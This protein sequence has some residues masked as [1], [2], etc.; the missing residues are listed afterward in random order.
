M[1]RLVR[2]GSAPLLVALFVLP[3]LPL[4][5][6]GRLG[7]E[8]PPDS[9]SPVDSSVDSGGETV[10]E[11]SAEVS[12]E[13][14]PDVPLDVP[15]DS[16][17]PTPKTCDTLV[18]AICGPDTATCCSKHSFTFGKSGCETAINYYCGSM[19][20]AVKAGTATYDESYLAGCAKAWGTQMKM[21]DMD[22]ITYTKLGFDCS[23]LFN[24]TKA[25]G[26]T[27][28]PSGYA[29]CKAPVGSSAYCDRSAKKCRV[30]T[31]VG[32]GA[33]CNFYGS[34]IHYCD[35]G[36]Y[37]DLTSSTS[38]CQTAKKL[39]DACDGP[40]DFSCGLYN[41]CKD[42]KCTPGL[43]DGADCTVNSECASYQCDKGKCT[44]PNVTLAGPYICGSGP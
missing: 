15:K 6:G 34:S 14:A 43:G 37:C 21:C 1:N 23:Q 28:N 11:T 44:D 24:G 17:P 19:V 42:N 26:D 10:S 3:A 41:V 29:E 36:L 35:L 38:V 31:V 30:Y 9:G 7:I 32:K 20:D 27:C 5:C 25:P 13:V 16:P 40:D 33:P 39:G 22:F 12:P 18:G 2:F 4:A 8:E